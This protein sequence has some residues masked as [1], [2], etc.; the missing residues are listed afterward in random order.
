[1]MSDSRLIVVLTTAAAEPEALRISRTL[2][3]EGLAACVQR[4]PIASTYLWQGQVEEGAEQ[5]LLIKTLAD[6][7]EEIEQRIQELSSYE[8]PEVVGVEVASV[9]TAYETWLRSACRARRHR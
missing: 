1:M 5:L 4:M 3:E 9:S 8:V 2:I 6:R 7:F